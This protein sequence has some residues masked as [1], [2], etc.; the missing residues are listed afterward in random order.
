MDNATTAI[1][2]TQY[3]F[4][5]F[6]NIRLVT[7]KLLVGTA[8][9]SLYILWWAVVKICKHSGLLLYSGNTVEVF[10]HEKGR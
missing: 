10:C 3:E 4:T 1:L 5:I 6:N 8:L 9:F 7:C 2:Q